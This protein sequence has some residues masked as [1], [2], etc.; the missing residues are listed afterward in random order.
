MTLHQP[1]NRPP[2]LFCG[3]ER[4]DGNA[5]VMYPVACTPQAWATGS[6]FQLLQV[7]INL[8]PD[9]A[10]T[11]CGFSTQHCQ[12]IN[13]LSLQNLRVGSTLLDLEFERSG[14]ATACRVAKKRGNLRV[15]IEA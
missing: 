1:Y 5:P 14:S 11:A 4:T 3:Y 8:V 12:I 13:K 15:V 2:E 9:A 7:M 6:I 10:I